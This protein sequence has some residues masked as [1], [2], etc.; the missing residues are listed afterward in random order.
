[1]SWRDR[2][3]IERI[4]LGAKRMQGISTLLGGY[5]GFEMYARCLKGFSPSIR[6]FGALFLGVGL[7]YDLEWLLASHYRPLF[8][9][10]FRKYNKQ[11]KEREFDLVDRKRE[12]F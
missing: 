12:W 2:E 11:V 8:I 10:Y 5:F 6:F 7:K 1:M 9:A 3:S 4:H